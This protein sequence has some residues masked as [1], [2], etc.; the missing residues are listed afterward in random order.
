MRSGPLLK[1]EASREPVA[2]RPSS[3]LISPFPP[4]SPP[5][6]H[7]LFP[8]A[9][10]C[11]CSPRPLLLI[12]TPCSLRH[13]PP[14]PRPRRPRHPAPSPPP[15]PPPPPPPVF[16]PARPAEDETKK[17]REQIA[18]FDGL[19]E[20][21]YEAPAV[22][23]GVSKKPYGPLSRGPFS[24][25]NRERLIVEVRSTNGKLQRSRQIL[26]DLIKSFHVDT[27]EV[28]EIKEVK[29]EIEQVRR[30]RT[31]PLLLR[32]GRLQAQAR[33]SPLRQLRG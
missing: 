32:F 15:P 21:Y 11:R 14:R 4:C 30:G 13:R 33:S 19:L 5:C 17:V 12:S 1:G 25:G 31:A 8:R 27:P 22:V 24:R 18:I 26:M 28:A 20:R 7:A 10:H 16:S 29:A 23:P 3:T 6:R 2:D 9:R